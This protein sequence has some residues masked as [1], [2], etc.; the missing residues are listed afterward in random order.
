M[1]INM[2]SVKDQIPSWM[3][4]AYIIHII[5]VSANVLVETPLVK[6]TSALVL[7]LAFATLVMR[8]KNAGEYLRYPGFWIY[9]LF[10]GSF[11]LSM[12]VNI[13]YGWHSNLKILI[14]MTI[15]FGGLYL[16][17]ERRSAEEYRKEMKISLILIIVMSCL[18][19][20]AS[21]VMLAVNFLSYRITPSGNSYIIGIAWWGRLYGV[22]VD[23]NYASVVA[24]IG[25]MSSIYLFLCTGQKKYRILLGIAGF[26]EL[27]NLAF[28]ASRT[29]T[30]AACTAVG[31]FTLIYLLQKKRRL[32]RC[33]LTSFLMIGLVFGA[34]KVLTLSYNGYAA[35]MTSLS[36]GQSETKK[37]DEKVTKIG[38]EQ[39]LSGDVSNRRF[40]LWQNALAYTE[41]NPIAG[42][43]FGNFIS[44]ARQKAPDSYLINNH[45]T[46]FDAFHNMFM[47][48]LA[49]QGIIGAAVFLYLVFR[50]LKYLAKNFRTA[51]AQDRTAL[52]F[53][54][55]TCLAVAV[56]SMFV[57]EILYV[58][59]QCSVLF[60]LL[61]G[62][63]IYFAGHKENPDEIPE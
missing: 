10:L 43:S 28:G 32:A 41:E 42:V 5:L 63:L 17:D 4:Y 60:W 40:D 47:D 31:A 11:I 38:R 34:E 62:Y 9:I 55:S 44:Y 30:V 12:I 36:A 39:E 33:I 27:T 59:N 1:K 16:F 22:H 61:W 18:L 26:L 46:T 7:L 19:N 2:T 21:L 8:L 20:L 56:S 49:S 14:W 37:K 6:V 50:N 23:P 45:F 25:L 48:L 13:R 53:L 57:S 54:F 35:L 51:A 3:K 58:N 24:T 29:G 52:A 15:W